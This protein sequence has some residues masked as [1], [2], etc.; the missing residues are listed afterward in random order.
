MLSTIA[1]QSGERDIVIIRAVGDGMCRAVAGSKR[2]NCRLQLLEFRLE[3][4][5][6]AT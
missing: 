4:P 1:D 2:S 6:S 3:M 5:E